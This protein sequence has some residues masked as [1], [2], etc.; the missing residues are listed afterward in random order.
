MHLTNWKARR[1][2]GRITIVGFD[3]EGEPAK[4]VGVDF[5]QPRKADGNHH[6]TI[7]AVDKNGDTHLLQI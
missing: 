2:G 4:I 3:L 6:H 7:E 1:A 5:I